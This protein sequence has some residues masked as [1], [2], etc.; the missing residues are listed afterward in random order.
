ML[1]LGEQYDLEE[2]VVDYKAMFEETIRTLAAIDQE[3]GLPED[4]NNSP[5]RTL[6]AIR[7]LKKG[8]V[9]LNGKK[10]MVEQVMAYLNL[11]AR[12]NYR[13][14]N[15]N[16]TPTAGALVIAQRLK[17]GYTV[18]QCKDVI[19]IKSNQWMGNEWDQYL[20]PQTLFRKSN[21]DKYLAEAEAEAK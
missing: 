1:H 14:E 2:F 3:L 10:Q 16:G 18:D 20:N 19:G 13:A 9:R 5:N 4:G 17:E 11:Q 8:G 15:P 7:A 21:F 12:R 6:E